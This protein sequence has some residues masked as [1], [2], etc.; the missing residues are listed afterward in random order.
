MVKNKGKVK[1]I[2]EKLAEYE[3][4]LRL[5]MEREEKEQAGRGSAISLPVLS[6]NVQ[7]VNNQHGAAGD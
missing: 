2:E 1:T 7:H 3:R 5:Q 6:V 4:M